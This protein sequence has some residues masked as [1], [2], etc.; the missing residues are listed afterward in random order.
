LAV[1]SKFSVLQ[2]IVSL[3]DFA[4]PCNPQKVNRQT[5]ASSEEKSFR[6]NNFLT[7]GRA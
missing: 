2:T 5:A 1:E 6:K 3:G 7:F 4:N